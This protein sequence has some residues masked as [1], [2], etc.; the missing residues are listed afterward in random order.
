MTPIVRHCHLAH[1]QVSRHTMPRFPWH[2]SFSYHI[3]VNRKLLPPTRS[4]DHSV[5]N[6]SRNGCVHIFDFMF[7]H[8]FSTSPIFSFFIT[9]GSFE[10]LAWSC[11]FRYLTNPFLPFVSPTGD[12]HHVTSQIRY[13]YPQIWNDNTSKRCQPRGYDPRGYD[14]RCC[15]TGRVT[16]Q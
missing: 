16:T 8:P 2:H 15:D 12:G 11:H 1:A 9:T 3:R 6:S 13:K 4:M 5:S 14:P 10:L 7:S